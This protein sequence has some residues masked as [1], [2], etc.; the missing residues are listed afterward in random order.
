M[1]TSKRRHRPLREHSAKAKVQ[2]MELS[3]AGTSI[4]VE[5]FAD[6]EKLGTLVIGWGSLT[7]FGNN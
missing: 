4:E 6:D 5:L 7:W 3:K 2:V 1:T